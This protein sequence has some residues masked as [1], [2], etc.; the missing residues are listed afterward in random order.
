MFYR[1]AFDALEVLLLHAPAGFAEAFT[2]SPVFRDGCTE[3]MRLDLLPSV[4]ARLGQTYRSL[5][6][7]WTVDN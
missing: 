6:D 3:A 7:S 2:L 4:A 5:V 1:N